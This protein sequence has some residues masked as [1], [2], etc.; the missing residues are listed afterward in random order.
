[1]FSSFFCLPMVFWSEFVN[2]SIL[3]TYKYNHLIACLLEGVLIEF[4]F[5]QTYKSNMLSNS[6]RYCAPWNGIFVWPMYLC[7]SMYVASREIWIPYICVALHSKYC[8]RV[9]LSN[10]KMHRNYSCNDLFI[11]IG[12]KKNVVFFVRLIERENIQNY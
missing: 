5:K 2:K 12:L 3:H 8:Y 6:G 7:R 4:Y 9:L 11:L 10:V 1:M